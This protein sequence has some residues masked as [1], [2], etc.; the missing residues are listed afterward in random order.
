M[1]AWRIVASC[2]NTCSH[3]NR[4]CVRERPGSGPGEPDPAMGS[5]A[6]R[7]VRRTAASAQGYAR[8]LADHLALVVDDAQSA[9]HEKGTVRAWVDDRLVGRLLLRSAVQP[10]VV[11]CPRGALLD[12]GRD[13]VRGSA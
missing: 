9:A 10:A 12:G 6:E 8:V 7:L 4:R 11:Q 2:T 5:I 1:S 3:K 13:G